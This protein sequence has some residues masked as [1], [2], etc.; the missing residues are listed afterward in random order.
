M[1]YRTNGVHEKA[2]GSFSSTQSLGP[3]Q[4]MQ[5]IGPGQK[6]SQLLMKKKTVSVRGSAGDL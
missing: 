2:T 3:F 1:T 6:Q 5:S 4:S